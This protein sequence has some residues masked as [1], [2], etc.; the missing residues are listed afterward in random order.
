LFCCARTPAAQTIGASAPDEGKDSHAY[1]GS[2]ARLARPD[3]GQLTNI[4]IL[5]GAELNAERERSRQ[6]QAGAPDTERE[7][8]LHERS[9][10]KTNKRTRTA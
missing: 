7:L 8:Q 3:D 1:K 9:T 2:S 6:L 10:P 5:L 4:A